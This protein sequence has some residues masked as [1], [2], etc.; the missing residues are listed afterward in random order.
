LPE[1][2]LGPMLRYVDETSATVWVETDAACTV[3]VLAGEHTVSSRTFTVHGHHYTLV[4]LDGLEPGASYQYTVRLDGAQAWPAVDSEFPP[5]R[6]RTIDPAR[7]LRLVF[8]SCRTSVPHDAAH[9]ISHGVDILRSYAHRMTDVDAGEWPS[10]LLLL[11]DQV[12]ADKPPP[13]MVDYISARRD[14]SEEPGTE[15]ADFT[16][17]AELYRLAWTEPALRW[18]LSTVPTAMVFDDHDLRDDWNTSAAWQETMRAQRWWRRRVVAGLGSYWVYQHL[19]NLPP[20]ELASDPLLAKLRAA[21]QDGGPLLDEFAW[22]AD[23]Q[24]EQNR[25]SYARDYGRVRVMVLDSRCARVLTPGRR[26]MLDP[27]EWAWFDDLATGD[28]DH[29]VIGSSLPVMLPGGLH[30]LESWNE[31]VC[32]G[33]WGARAARVGEKIRQ[34]IDLEHWAAFRDSFDALARVVDEIAEGRRGGPPASVLFLSGDVHYSYL[35]RAR[36]PRRETAVYQIVCSPI[37]NPLARTLRLLNGLASFG[38]AG[39][40]GRALARSAGVAKPLFSWSIP[41]GPFF[42]NALATID[43]ARRDAV[44]RFDTARIRRGHPEL[45]AIAE[46]PLTQPAKEPDDRLDPVAGT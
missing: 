37:R 9:L 7:P 28:L 2:V 32:D 17:Y 41:R 38:F 30:Q 5:S 1:L 11:G 46:Q 12:Y 36:L 4:V 23:V 19:G 24:P 18:M 27:A 6:I 25:W 35:A 14:T 29:L 39:L 8:G 13:E 20:D 34:G 16:E 33:A 26:A 45:G 10:L 40:V 31:A 3:E 21:E 42:Y 15:I 44:L 43:L 22:A